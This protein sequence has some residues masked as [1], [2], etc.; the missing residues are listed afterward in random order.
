M[1]HLRG[2]F[3][4]AIYD[5]EKQQLFCARDRLGKKPFKYY[6]DGN[7]FLFAS[8]LK[9]ILTQREYHREV[10]YTAIHHYLTL[11]Y[12]P[13]PLT[14]FKN[15]YKLEPGHFL[16]I[17]IPSR[18]L[19]KEQ[20]WKL[21]FE[22][23]HTWSEDE[24]CQRI[25][26]KLRES[27][28]LR[29]ISDVPLG[30]FL[31]GG[32]D[33]SAIVALMSEATS[34]VRTFS[35]GFNESTHNELPYARE[36]AQHFGTQHTEFVVAPTAAEIL[37]TLVEHFEEPFADSS[38][39]PSYY[40]SKLTRQQ[41]TVALNG[42]GGDENF[43]G[44]PR[45]SVQK[46]ALWSDRFR[47]FPARVISPTISAAANL[48]RA[49]LLEKAKRFSQTL[50]LDYTHRYAAYIGYFLHYQKQN[51]YTDEFFAAH[52]ASLS[53]DLLSQ[54]FERSQA[55]DKLDQTLFTDI[56]TYLPDDLLVKM[57]IATMAVGLEARSPLLDHE[58][59]ELTARMPSTYKLRGFLQRKYIF[60]RALT[61][62]LPDSI[63]QR[64]KQGFSPPLAA[65]LRGELKDFMYD[66]LLSSGAATRSF[67]KASSV[68]ALADAHIRG[69]N[70]NSK[71]LWV[72]LM[73]E[74]WL[75]RFFPEQPSHT[76]LHI[77][78]PPHSS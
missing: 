3:A 6:F 29:L 36:V 65:W 2:M 16:T 9:A 56:T 22:P 72:L 76:P 59:M 45:Y 19:H 48:F 54:A 47:P 26:E 61:G 78:Q 75:Q 13:A 24:W 42:D 49:P 52:A 46:F 34:Q 66:T 62:L 15:I 14:G 27:V 74:L 7:V 40:L 53:E 4:F 11:Q 64:S 57:D 55:S 70:D 51:L 5:Q 8:E 1:G 73:L 32:L 50:P 35:I 10:D 71:S 18:Q 17:D 25:L 20:Y 77:A 67:L 37:P 28:R 60:R 58:F 33:S 68:Q 21:T 38:A 30:A 31:S 69:A 44:Y 63:I 41:V 12:V 43:A 39:W 23:K